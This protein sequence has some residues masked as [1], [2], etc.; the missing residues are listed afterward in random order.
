M[1]YQVQKHHLSVTHSHI[2]FGK[3]TF[4]LSKDSWIEHVP[5]CP[6]H[7]I[8]DRTS[9]PIY[10]TYFILQFGPGQILRAGR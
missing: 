3:R 2:N 10:I 5:W 6:D 8:L 7:Q 4:A 9:L 1:R